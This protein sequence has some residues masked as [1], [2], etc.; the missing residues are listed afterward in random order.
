MEYSSKQKVFSITIDSQPDLN[1]SSAQ[2]PSDL[3]LKYLHD[4]DDESGKTLED[5]LKLGPWLPS[6]LLT[7]IALVLMLT[8]TLIAVQVISDELEAVDAAEQDILSVLLG[9]RSTQLDSKG[10]QANREYRPTTTS[11]RHHYKYISSDE[12]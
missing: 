3:K 7:V 11:G 4:G 1:G 10:S 8:I 12:S 6:F 2:Q 9:A 5:R